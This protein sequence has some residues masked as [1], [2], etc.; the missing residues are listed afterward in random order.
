[1]SIKSKNYRFLAAALLSTLLSATLVGCSSSGSSTDKTP[2]AND[3]GN[4]GGNNSGEG[5]DNS[6][7]E[8]TLDTQVNF[9]VENDT[10]MAWMHT[11]NKQAKSVALDEVRQSTVY[12]AKIALAE[13]T[14][15]W[16]DSYVYMSVPRSGKNKVG[17]T[18]TDGAEFAADTGMTMSWT[19]FIYA[20]DTWVEIDLNNGGVIGSADDI[21]IRPTNLD[22]DVQMVDQDTVKVL[23]PYSQAGYRF[24]VEFPSEQMTSY[25][26]LAGGSGQ[27]TSEPGPGYPKVHTEP[28]NSM[29]VFA[30]PMLNSAQQAEL[31]PDK[32]ADNVYQVK[33]GQVPDLDSISKSTLYFGPGTYTMPSDYHAHLA[34]NVNWVYLAPGAYVKGAFQFRDGSEHYKVTGYGVLSGENYVYEADTTNDYKH[35]VNDNCHETCVK[36]LRFASGNSAQKLTLQGITVNE[37]P[38]HSFVVYGNESQ[39]AMDVQQYKQ[40]GGWY[41]QTDGL[42]LYTGS[43]IQDSFFHANDDVIKIYHSNVTAN[44]IQVW[45]VEN[46]PVIQWGWWPREINN[47]TVENIDVIHNRIFWKDQKFN[48]CIINSS[49]VWT[50]MNADNTA[51]PN[52]LIQN[53]TIRN[54]RSE[55]MNPCAMRLFAVSDWKN[56][57]IDGLHIEA[58]NDLP[59]SSQQSLFKAYFN[60][61]R[62]Q[63]VE[64]GEGEQGVKIHNYTVAGQPVSIE[65]DNWQAE[66]LGRI[67]FDGELADNWTASSDMNASCTVQT[68]TFSELADIN[69]GG[70]LNLNATSSS[71]LPVRYF[72][73]SGGV[74]L[75]GSRLIAGDFAAQATIVAAQ[76]GSS[77][78]CPA[79]AEQSL[80][81]LGSEPMYIGGS[82][83]GWSPGNL[84]MSWDGIEYSASVNFAVGDYEM[85]FANKGDWSGQDWANAT[86]L[87]GTVEETTGGGANIKFTI[88][89]AG[90]YLIK[91]N[92]DT[93]AYQIIKI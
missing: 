73:L 48:T 29:M 86:G 10:L 6:G 22:F 85:K 18:E 79:R 5:G 17:Y 15:D 2:D 42:E 26:T 65:L 89:E 30:S 78:Y 46:G 84:E 50:D 93:L 47:V 80:T 45:K 12:S 69:A 1:M 27:L 56:I 55:G 7:G 35:N 76:D 44:N 21:I 49:S 31:V 60:S 37:P 61:N 63:Q 41:W 54:V 68:I 32:D 19:S 77:V 20:Q 52:K 59:K 71:G 72:V 92:P 64:I 57:V 38:Y 51:D 23:V 24:S 82:W 3:G 43:Q 11:N 58:W 66:K 9:T 62:T 87:T 83:Q 39:F 28:K 74:S 88:S 34:S 81:I 53:L 67:S 14:N 75:D 70:E 40:V 13:N 33:P 25:N 4:D 91:F 90:D 8:Q 36:M 16:F